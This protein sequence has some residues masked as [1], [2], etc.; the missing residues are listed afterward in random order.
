MEAQ[1]VHIPDE[2]LDEIFSR[3]SIKC[4]MQFKCVCKL[5]LFRI[6]NF[7]FHHKTGSESILLIEKSESPTVSVYSIDD[8]KFVSKSLSILCNEKKY[9][10]K[11][12]VVSNSC[13]GLVI[14]GLGE[15]FFMFNPLTRYLVKV[16][17]L[18]CMRKNGNVVIGLCYNASTN[19]YKVVVRFTHRF[20]HGRVFVVAS[21]K[22]KR[23]VQINFP[24]VVASTKAGPMVNGRMHW[25]VNER[26]NNHY[27]RFKKIVCF[28][29]HKNLFEEF[30]SPRDF[31]EKDSII[32]LGVSGECLCMATKTHFY[33]SIFVMKEYGI[34]ESWTYVAFFQL[35]F[36]PFLFTKTD[37]ILG[38]K[39]APHVLAYNMKK[40]TLRV[41]NLPNVNNL[42]DAIS[43][44]QNLASPVGYEWDEN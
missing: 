25:T 40:N 38:K 39:Y 32:G 16:L 7:N 14:I 28:D 4:L 26:A 33:V 12:I 11:R 9:H 8:D 3:L 30:P 19:D 31:R 29:L 34:R 44:I 37:V 20:G 35:D 41:F 18:N 24:F 10:G 27:S 21:L 15:S 43:F 36:N 6:S 1:L 42:L 22:T 2:I 13:N 5:W 23:W 17:A